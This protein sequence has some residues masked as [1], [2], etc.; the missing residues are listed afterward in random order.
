MIADDAIADCTRLA[1]AV[2]DDDDVDVDVAE[3]HVQDQEPDQD[4]ARPSGSCDA[5]PSRT[6][7]S[8]EE[9]VREPPAM[10]ATMGCAPIRTVTRALALLK[11]LTIVA[12][13]WIV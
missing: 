1:Q 6:S 8:W 4:P 10:A 9:T 12:E 2:D 13:S 3:R 7:S 5:E 11:V